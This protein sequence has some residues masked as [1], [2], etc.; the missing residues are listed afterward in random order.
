MVEPGAGILGVCE[1]R[2]L[3][4]IQLTVQFILLSHKTKNSIRYIEHVDVPG[5]LP[6]TCEI[7]SFPQRT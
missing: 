2:I 6:P 5:R 3:H 7:H 4:Q 1:C